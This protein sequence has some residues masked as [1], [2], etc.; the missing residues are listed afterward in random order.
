MNISLV[1]SI[2]LIIFS[3]AE[4][5]KLQPPEDLCQT[6][7][8]GPFYNLRY[9]E[10]LI[11]NVSGLGNIKA[12]VYNSL[13]CNDCPQT[14]WEAIDYRSIAKEYDALKAQPN[15]PRFWVLDSM[16]N[17]NPAPFDFCA[18]TFGEIDMTL[19]A[20]VE[21]AG[22]GGRN[23]AYKTNR[24]SRQTTFHFNKGRQIYILQSPQKQCYIMQSFTQA[25]DSE[26]QL[27]ELAGLG[28]RLDL[29]KG[30]S[31]QTHLLE[32]RFELTTKDGIAEVITDELKNTYQLMHEAC[33]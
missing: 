4:T 27:D 17:N 31:F 9:C 28:E 6:A 19:M 22:R 3:T 18:H 10:I 8:D 7:I 2:L 16:A 26:L 15:G 23:S 21:V 24:V 12:D 14:A 11:A 25:V 20:S 30:W 1:L 5:P 13:G 32:E 33:W 29:P